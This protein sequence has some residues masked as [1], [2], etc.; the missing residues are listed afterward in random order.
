MFKSSNIDSP[1]LLIRGTIIFRGKRTCNRSIYKFSC[2]DYL[3]LD[4]RVF[5]PKEVMHIE[6]S[7]FECNVSRI[8]IV[9]EQ[10]SELQTIDSYAFQ[11][12]KLRGIRIPSSVLKIG[13]HA[14]GSSSIRDVI[15]FSD[16]QID[17]IR[18]GMCCNMMKLKRI[19]IPS[20]VEII[21]NYAFC[22]SIFLE[23]LEFAPD[24]R[25]REIRMEAF[26]NTS[27]L[28]S[29]RIPNTVVLISS[30][31]FERSRLIIVDFEPES[32]LEN[33]GD[34]AFRHC[35][36]L[37]KMRLPSSLVSIGKE[38]FIGC[39]LIVF[40][41]DENSNLTSIGED[42]FDEGRFLPAKVC[43]VLDRQK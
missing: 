24:S 23:E 12:S 37:Q 17:R 20:S 30:S 5:V 7:A 26:R 25:L 4:T 42:A 28:K 22:A 9:F 31:A 14:F 38:A 11:K 15:N 16:L 8:D 40:T 35:Y 41:V 13:P 18:T 33:I 1:V 32:Q 2:K 36:K 10:K 27:S 39:P 3:D 6:C 29:I 43:E 34:F 19:T 21:D